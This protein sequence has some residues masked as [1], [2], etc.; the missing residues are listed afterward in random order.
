MIKKLLLT[1]GLILI[2]IISMAAFKDE[3]ES[4]G[5]DFIHFNGM[6]G[7]FYFH[8]MMGG[9]VALFDYDNDGDL[10][11]YLNQGNM[12]GKKPLDKAFFKPQNRLPLTDRL[13]RNDSSKSGIKFSDVTKEAKINAFGYG[14]GVT[15]ADIDNDGDLD[16]YVLNY[17]K[18]QML[19]N[20]NDGTFSDITTSSKTGCNSW[21]SS[22]SFI[23]F[24]KDGFLD[25]YVANYVDYKIS[26]L[27]QCKSYDGSLDYCSPQ[28]YK[29]SKDILYHNNGDGTFSDVS[30]RSGV[31]DE[32]APGLGVVAADY[33]NDGW[34]DLYVANDGASNILWINNKL[35]GFVNKALTSGVAVNMTGLA[36]ASM[37][38][39]AADFD[40]DG[41]VDLFMTHLNRQT[42]TLYVNNGKGWFSDSGV[43]MGV[44]S[45]SFRSTGFGAMWVDFD[46]DGLLD[47]FSAN[48]AVIKEPQQM[49]QKSKYPLKQ[50][51]Q[52]WHNIGN[53]KYKEV[54]K[55]Q[56]NSF[57]NPGVSRGAAYGDLDNDGD[58]DIIV[59]NNSSSPQVLINDNTENN[60]I[61]LKLIRSGLNRDDYSARVEVDL[62]GN[63]I[64]RQLKTDGSY[65]S[66]HDN[67]IL[68]G[69]GGFSKSPKVTVYWSDGEVQKI[70]NLKINKYSNIE[71]EH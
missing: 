15:Y 27:M 61:G 69:L 53:N 63:K 6:S 29:P 57:L 8:E 70:N 51:N 41:D 62:G 65:A 44:A 50:K 28:G 68:V 64:Y 23:D 26:N 39:D 16:I 4:S 46:N 1:L 31:S 34:I 67:R 30:S 10:D 36:E 21:S 55:R 60:W 14:M 66:A 9:G 33:N 13:Y 37:G 32:M 24:D 25:L 5:I 59:T 17:E 3:L 38:V 40:N 12:I 48:G 7:E 71:R 52:I 18:N 45:S 19:L 43:R 22:A 56:D 2:S 49:K 42:N 11:V 54:S 20:N 47:L 58:L 35:G